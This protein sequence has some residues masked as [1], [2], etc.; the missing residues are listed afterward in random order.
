MKREI[1]QQI[2]SSVMRALLRSVVV[3]VYVNT[4]QKLWSKAHFKRTEAQWENCS[5]QFSVVTV[6]KQ[7]IPGSAAE[8]TV[9]V[10]QRSE[11]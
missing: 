4:V 8:V 3:K 2:S 11:R 6:S 10:S 1:D 7:I 5:V 9:S